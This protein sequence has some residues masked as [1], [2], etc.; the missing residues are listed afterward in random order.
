MRI[1]K[2]S[3]TTP[4]EVE[5]V[6]EYSTST[7]DTYSAD[8]LNKM[9][10]YST[11]EETIIGIWGN[12]KPIY[13]KVFTISAWP[14]ATLSGFDVNIANVDTLITCRAMSR[15][16]NE[17]FAVPSYYSTSYFDSLLA[18]FSGNTLTRIR[19][20]SNSNRSNYSGFAILEYTKTTD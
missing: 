2:T 18:E 16:S 17:S 1:K 5:I 7:T 6:N 19:L 4:T 14:N 11:T 20:K 12:N 13:R 10:R 3:Q 15:A 8:Y 9:N